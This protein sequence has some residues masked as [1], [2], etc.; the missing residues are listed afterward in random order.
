MEVKRKTRVVAALLAV[1]L[2]L[3]GAHK[4]Y[5]GHPKLGILYIL[6]TCTV[7]GGVFTGWGSIIEGV[8]FVTKSDEDFQRVYVLEGRA[9]F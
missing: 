9:M 1:F 2:G 5:L 8:L 6:L 4:F 3:V 7:I